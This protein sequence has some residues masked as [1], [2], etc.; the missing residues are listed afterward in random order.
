MAFLTVL[1]LFKHIKVW[2]AQLTYQLIGGAQVCSSTIV[3]SL[4]A[5]QR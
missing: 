5:A 2:P 3:E 4:P 1:L